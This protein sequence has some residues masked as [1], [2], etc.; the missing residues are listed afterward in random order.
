[1]ASF[2]G[3]DR[4]AT[5][6]TSPS[7]PAPYTDRQ[8][9]HRSTTYRHCPC[10]LQRSLPVRVASV[11]SAPFTLRVKHQ[12]TR[13]GSKLSP[14]PGQLN[15]SPCTV[16]VHEYRRRA[17]THAVSTT[18]P[19]AGQASHHGRQHKSEFATRVSLPVRIF[20]K[21]GREKIRAENR[22]NKLTPQNTMFG[23]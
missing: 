1:M 7:A 15:P 8:T 16:V 14:P 3:A 22:S 4:R 21:P 5:A 20:E 13:R 23:I 2:R 18:R 12:T 11:S 10:P 6:Q 17:A 19:A 9:A